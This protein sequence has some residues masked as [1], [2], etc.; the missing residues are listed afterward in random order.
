M[1]LRRICPLRPRRP[2]PSSAP[3]ASFLLPAVSVLHRGPAGPASAQAA[4]VGVCCQQGAGCVRGSLAHLGRGR[5]WG[6]QRP[7]LLP[8][9]QGQSA[10]LFS[11]SG[12]LSRVCPG[13]KLAEQRGGALGGGCWSP[14]TSH[15][16]PLALRTRSLLLLAG[17]GP[18]WPSDPRPGSRELPLSIAPIHLD[19]HLWPR[20]PFLNLAGPSGVRMAGEPEG[21]V[22][23]CS[24]GP[25]SWDT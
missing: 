17:T 11:F 5:Q 21:Q 20:G 14:P 23:P 1:S 16:P 13:V 3:R 25:S 2:H 7:W 12:C 8:T 6:W 22:L 18:A 15:L 4:S 10:H 19:A 24:E 9:V